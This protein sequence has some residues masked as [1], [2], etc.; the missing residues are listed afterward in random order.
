VR[1]PEQER[2]VRIYVSAFTGPIAEGI[3]VSCDVLDDRRTFVLDAVP[4]G[5]WFIHAAAVARRDDKDP[6]KREPLC[7]KASRVQLG[8]ETRILDLDLDLH[9]TGILDPPILTAL[10][11]L[12]SRHLPA[13]LDAHG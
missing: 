2:P 4:D 1:L 12:D 9:P 3:P 6:W 11:E 8:I 5:E 13:G 7:V 10:P